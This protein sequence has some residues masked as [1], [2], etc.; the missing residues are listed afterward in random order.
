MAIWGKNLGVRKTYLYPA[1]N[2][3]GEHVPALSALAPNAHISREGVPLS[4]YL[5]M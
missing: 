2:M 1:Q 5:S 4:F 3:D